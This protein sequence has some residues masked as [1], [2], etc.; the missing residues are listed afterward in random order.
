VQLSQARVEFAHR[1]V[2][3]NEA[4][5]AKQLISAQERD[6]MVTQAKL[7][8]EEL[9]KDKENLKLRTIL[10]RSTGWSWNG[11]SCRETCSVWTNRSC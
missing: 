3:R 2:E 5:F 7:H 8:E 6:E 11:A 1:K 4:L 9:N 10:S